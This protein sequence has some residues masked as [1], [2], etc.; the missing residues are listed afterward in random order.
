M[1]EIEINFPANV[2]IKKE[3]DDTW[4]AKLI[5]RIDGKDFT[6]TKFTDLTG[7]EVY[8]KF[9][10]EVPKN[11]DVSVSEGRNNAVELLRSHL[12]NLGS[13]T[14]VTATEVQD[15]FLDAINSLSKDEEEEE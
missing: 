11:T 4:T 2:T 1:S 6:I 3:D 9:G 7:P 12:T 8:Y 5:R 13:R 14:I 10:Y 15:I